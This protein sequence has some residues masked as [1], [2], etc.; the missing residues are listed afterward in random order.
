MFIRVE[1][2]YIVT[3]D[4]PRLEVNDVRP[5]LAPDDSRTNPTPTSFS[6][7][8]GELFSQSTAFLRRIPSRNTSRPSDS[9]GNVLASL[10]T[11]NRSVDVKSKS[12]LDDQGQW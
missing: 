1:S 12:S 6:F 4:L 8:Y 11:L 5:V 9:C 2:L 7:R 3:S 10:R